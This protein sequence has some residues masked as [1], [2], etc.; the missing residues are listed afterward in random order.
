M[1]GGGN[2]N[3]I[4]SPQDT[5]SNSNRCLLRIS[6]C[7]FAFSSSASASALLIQ[8]IHTSFE[9]FHLVLIRGLFG[10]YLFQRTDVLSSN[11]VVHFF[12]CCDHLITKTSGLKSKPLP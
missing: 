5:E 12:T 7:D 6:N 8:H 9:L 2:V 10:V 3:N 4:K 1:K 11:Q